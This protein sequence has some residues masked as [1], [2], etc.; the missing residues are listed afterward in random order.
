MLDGN[1]LVPNYAGAEL[2]VLVTEDTL[3]W[4]C[5]GEGREYLEYGDLKTGDEVYIHGTV[6]NGDFTAERVVVDKP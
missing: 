5:T 2:Q 6:S 3:Y 4:L 1:P